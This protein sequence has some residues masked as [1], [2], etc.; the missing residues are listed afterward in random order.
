MITAEI[1]S[2]GSEITS[3][4]TLNT[5]SKF[6]A[7]MLLEIGIEPLYHTSVDDDEKRLENIINTAIKR[8]DL[9]ITTGG[10]GPTEDDLTKEVIAKAFDLKLIP[11]KNM[12]D[13]IKSIF[14]NS[15]SIMTKNNIKQSFKIETSEFLLNS[16]GT[17]PGIFLSRNGKKIILLP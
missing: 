16:V 11:D 7:N 3:G 5:N 15:S 1:I 17:A 14:D 13:T 9:I 10:L 6:I 2:V 12:E 8:V 4:S